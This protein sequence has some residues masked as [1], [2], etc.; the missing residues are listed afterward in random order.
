MPGGR[1]EPDLYFGE[2]NEKMAT[3][4]DVEKLLQSFIERGLPGALHVV[5]R[6]KT[7]F[8]GYFGVTDLTTVNHQ[9]CADDK[10]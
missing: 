1:F 2:R 9:G 5:Q 6:G 4:K 8:E 7:L 3:K 10:M